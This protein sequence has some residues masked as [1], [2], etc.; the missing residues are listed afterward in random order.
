[1]DGKEAE[2]A[3]PDAGLTPDDLLGEFVT[4]KG[5]FESEWL[6]VAADDGVKFVR[7]TAIV[8]VELAEESR[9]TFTVLN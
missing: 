7:R 3:L 2:I 9:P 5:E 8:S 1:M 6:R 4:G